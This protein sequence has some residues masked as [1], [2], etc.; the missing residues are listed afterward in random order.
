MTRSH[1][2]LLAVLILITGA[3]SFT[4]SAQAA[5][6]TVSL[7][8]QDCT[9]YTSCYTSLSA[10]EAAR[11]RDLVAVDQQETARIEGTWT[12]PDTA[13]LS[14]SG[15]TTDAT[16]FIKIYTAPEA[17]HAGVWDVGRYRLEV[18]YNQNSPF[19]INEENVRIE[20]LQISN[21]GTQEYS[22]GINVDIVGVSDIRISESIIR[23]ANSSAVQASGLYVSSGAAGSTIRVWNNIVYDINRGVGDYSGGLIFRGSGGQTAY[24]YNN[25]VFN[26][27][28]G[29]LS[30]SGNS[31]ITVIAK[32]NISYNNT[33]NYDGGIFA[34]AS[35][36]NLSGPL[37]IDAPGSNPRN[38]ATVTFI[39]VV[40]KNFHLSSSDTGA[41]DFG[42]TLSSD[43][44]LALS[45]DI[46]GQSRATPYDIGADE[47]SGGTPPPS[48][49]TAPTVPAGLTATTVS[50]SQINLSWSAST[51]STG[52]TGYRIY[53]G[54]TQIAT[55][56]TTSYSNTTLTPS[57][58]Y[59]YTISAYD[60]AGN[61]SA[62]SA[63]A[64]A[65]TQAAAAP[66]TTAP[67]TPT[68]LSATPISSTQINLS[69]TASTDA[70]GVTGYRIYRN[71]AQITTSAT[72]SYSDATL[73]P[74]TSYTYTVSAYDAAGN[75]SAQTA[76]VSGTTQSG[77]A[78]TGRTLYV[79]SATGNDA[80]T[81]ANNSASTP[82][83]TIGRAAWG[84][85]NY[86]S[87]NAA[88]AAQAGDTVLIEAG[89]Y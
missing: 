2:I 20:G 66:D 63:S 71:G 50:S 13:P 26:V 31:G 24:A 60:A 85:T 53:R 75:A 4:P 72:N 29:I 82:W 78:A 6:E 84:S 55:S 77:A 46:D 5:V 43:S 89:I 61:V 12:N 39:D 54:G 83:R 19:N 16:H 30:G 87:P 32:N 86:A 37:Q 70:V 36:N 88:Q 27:Y 7:I 62:Q 69:W 49:T 48:D 56:V 15:W 28:K 1:T 34:A 81:Y 41:R 10:W 79:N 40:N 22:N 25:T 58:A 17:R 47:T 18:L 67:T 59:S 52:V 51:D 80:T 23:G 65:T 64:S 35:T 21:T 11:Q 57:T 68:N 44:L 3:F 9:G 38:S 76:G 14:I 42:T 8:R 74:S 33:Y 45:T 73:S